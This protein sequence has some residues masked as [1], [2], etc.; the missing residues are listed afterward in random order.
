MKAGANSNEAQSLFSAEQAEE[1]AIHKK[2]ILRNVDFHVRAAD[3]ASAS[4]LHMLFSKI[5][6]GWILAFIKTSGIDINPSP[7]RVGFTFGR[8]GN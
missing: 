4:R 5:T 3:S 8:D 7:Y 2:P 6:D 1:I